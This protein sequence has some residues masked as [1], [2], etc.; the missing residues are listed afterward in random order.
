M[1]NTRNLHMQSRRFVKIATVEYDIYVK[2]AIV[3]Y[4]F[5]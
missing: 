4:D 3:E 5:L 2:I 1:R